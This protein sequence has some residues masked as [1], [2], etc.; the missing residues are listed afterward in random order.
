MI[1]TLVL[2]SQ[3]ILKNRTSVFLEGDVVLVRDYRAG[4]KWSK[5]QIVKPLS[6]FSYIVRIS[7]NDSLCKRH[8]RS[9]LM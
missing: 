5:A 6:P 7:D 3:V 4:R 8:V 1:M 2:L 9:Y